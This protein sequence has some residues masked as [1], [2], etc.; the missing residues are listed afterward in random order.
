[1]TSKLEAMAFLNELESAMEESLGQRLATNPFVKE[2]T[3]GSRDTRLIALYLI[4]VYHFTRHNPVN[5]A[6]VIRNCLDSGIE[7]KKRL[8]YMK[9]CLNHALEELGHEYM[10][11]HDLKSFGLEIEESDLPKPLPETQAFIA[12]LYSAASSGNPLQRLGYSYWAENCYK[13]FEPLAQVAISR[14][15]L[16]PKNLSF[17]IQHGKIDESHA[18]EV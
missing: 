16:E 3:A 2:L 11:F 8:H 9:F 13:V 1:M 18:A 12:Y 5:Q 14:M 4:E 17:F 15:G 6:I 10:A 7:L